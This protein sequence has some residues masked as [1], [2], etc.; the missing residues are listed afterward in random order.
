MR[1]TASL[2]GVLMLI[3]GA[4]NAADLLGAYVGGAVGQGWTN[5]TDLD[6]AGASYGEFNANHSAFKVMA[7]IRPLPLLG[8]EVAYVDFGHAHQSL[9]GPDSGSAEVHL[10]GA[11]AFAILYLPV[12]I[13]DVYA[14]AGLASLRTTSS[15]ALTRVGVGTCVIGVPNCGSYSAEDRDTNARFAGGVGAQLKLG[16]WAV[17]A[18][19][20]RFSAA[21]ANPALA[22]VGFTW[23]FL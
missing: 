17:R 23:T 16:P 8:A 6:V 10:R 20:E 11:A 15:V 7:G 9:A 3:G 22:T 19:Y 21:G 14:K 4:A 5:G 2:C 12:P 1:K 18:E 13:V